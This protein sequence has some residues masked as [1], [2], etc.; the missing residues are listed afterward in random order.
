MIDRYTAGR[1][2]MARNL[3]AGIL[4]EK[5]EY[6]SLKDLCPKGQELRPLPPPK[7]VEGHAAV[8]GGNYVGVHNDYTFYVVKA[9]AYI[10]E[11]GYGQGD[12]WMGI[13]IPPH[14]PDY[15][16]TIYREVLEAASLVGDGIPGGRDL[17]REA[18]IVYFD[19]S[20]RNA[21][22]W[23][24]PG[25][26]SF[27]DEEKPDIGRDLPLARDILWNYYNS[28]YGLD[29][30]SHLQC[31]GRDDCVREFIA[32]A[33]ARPMV[34]GLVMELAA[35]R[36]AEGDL[37]R[38]KWITTLEVVEKLYLYM[39][40]IESAWAGGGMPLF[41]SKTSTSTRLCG[42][43][44]SDLYY[45]RILHR[46]NP[47]PGYIAWEG[48]VLC[49]AYEITRLKRGGRLEG[50]RPICPVEAGDGEPRFYPR[51]L[52][53]YDFYV[54]RLGA[55]EFYVRLARGRPFMLAN[56]LF[57]MRDPPETMDDVYRLVEEALARAVS[58]PLVDGY[59][60]SLIMAHYHARILPEE[61]LA[62]ARGVGLE[63]EPMARS[64]LRY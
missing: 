63:L 55:V 41:L 26:V 22:R 6:A 61:A 2:R 8:D 57:D 1:I 29:S 45:L 12:A 3:I 54:K 53:L 20:I 40:A 49:G 56:L 17:A 11:A 23:W 32:R 46:G 27:G 15:R 21:I 33:P 19:G 59:P 64:K 62:V 14:H 37:R 36:L 24:S 50:A 51:E 13:L 60:L 35:K 48:G 39:R 43:K 34:P 25:A 42:E 16:V 30:L 4:D 52:G 5:R 10:H 38:S 31:N 18:G 58:T 7:P 28:G 9:W 47:D 44:H